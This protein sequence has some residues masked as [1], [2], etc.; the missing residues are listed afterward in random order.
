M[1]TFY[2]Q[3]TLTYNGVTKSSNITVGQITEALT[4]EKTAVRNT[5]AAGDSIVYVIS[6][7]NTVG[8]ALTELTVTDDL[9][10]YEYGEDSLVPLTYVEGSLLYYVNGELQ[11]APEVTSVSPLTLTGIDLPAGGT[12]KLIYETKIN[13]YASPEAGGEITNTAVISTAAGA[14]LAQA[15]ETIT[16]ANTAQLEISKSIA[17]L[18]V[19]ENGE[20]TYSFVIANTGNSEAGAADSAVIT[21][22]FSP[23]LDNIEVT[24]NGTEWTQGTEYTYDMATGTF[25]TAA[26]KIT[27]PAAQ[28]TR[29]DQGCYSVIPGTA[30]LT[31]SGTLVP[32]QQSAEQTN[33]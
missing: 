13:E 18:T 19:A 8:T 21:D 16:A 9:G 15:S 17:P 28:Y 24:F 32:A 29:G 22:V 7:I 25:A 6:M 3:A 5:Y 26:G 31:V 27:V 14:A 11:T 12:A 4:A 1:A 10:E 2:N 23:V 30:T 33:P 20:I